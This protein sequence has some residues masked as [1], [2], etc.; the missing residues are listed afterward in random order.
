MP[1]VG[2]ANG[3]PPIRHWCSQDDLLAAYG[4]IAHDGINF[5]AQEI[6]DKYFIVTT[7][8][9][10]KQGGNH[11][12]DWSAKFGLIPR[13]VWL[14]IYACFVGLWNGQQCQTQQ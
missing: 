3:V 6:I 5:G 11:G 1:Q 14:I 8:F 10:K 9:V 12:G 2:T 7:D 13:G 4:W